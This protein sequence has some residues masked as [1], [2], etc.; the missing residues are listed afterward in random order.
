MISLPAA[1]RR[2]LDLLE[3]FYQV[4]IGSLPL[5]TV[6]GLA[7]GAVVWIH[8]RGTVRDEREAPGG[9]PQGGAPTG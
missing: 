3:Q 1:L 2:P 6:A 9:G 5:G 8:L 4:I 7:V